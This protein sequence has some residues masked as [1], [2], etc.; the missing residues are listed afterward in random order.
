MWLGYL[1]PPEHPLCYSEEQL[2]FPRL[3]NSPFYILHSYYYNSC[4]YCVSSKVLS[5]GIGGLCM[6]I[7]KKHYPDVSDFIL[8]W[9]LTLGYWLSRLYLYPAGNHIIFPEVNKTS[10]NAL[11]NGSKDPLNRFEKLWERSTGSQGA[12]LFQ[13]WHRG[14]GDSNLKWTGYEDL[15]H[16][17]CMIYV[18][19]TQGTENGNKA[20]NG[21]GHPLGLRERNKHC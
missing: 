19:R 20:H 15:I 14:K 2:P 21:V 6:E 18:S 3:P 9:K 13:L 11:G 8:N 16:I 7:G 4:A 17:I 5:E 12:R 10:Q 1:Q